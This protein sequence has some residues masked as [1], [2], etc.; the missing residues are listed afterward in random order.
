MS[1]ATTKNIIRLIIS[2]VG[3]FIVELIGGVDTILKALLI[4]MIVDYL[5]GILVAFVFHKSTKTKNG[6][7]SSKEGLK[8]IVKKLCILLFVGLAHMLDVVMGTQY[9]RAMTII[10]FL[11]NE[12]LSVLENMGLMGIKYPVFFVK[13]LEVLREKSESEETGGM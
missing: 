13:A 7:A 12:G 10:F 2:A 11:A 3:G 5:T 4:F 8:G 9:I 6:G 1:I